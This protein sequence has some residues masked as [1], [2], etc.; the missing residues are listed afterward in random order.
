MRYAV[1]KNNIVENVI[2]ADEG[3][4]VPN[5]TLVASD[6][7]AIGWVYLDGA[8]F[9]PAEK[10]KSL[11]DTKAWSAARVAVAAA[12]ARKELSGG[13]RGRTSAYRAKKAVAIR[14]VTFESGA[15]SALARE[16]AA[17]GMSVADLAA[18]ILSKSDEEM[19]AIVKVDGIEVEAKTSIEK[20]RTRANATDIA[21]TAITEITAIAEA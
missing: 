4:D 17:R 1:V 10:Q 16:A 9:P 13:T 11:L 2:S 14:A 8:L 7:A 18:L 6:E 5:R 21:D 19:E 15:V 20:A 12:G 3:Y